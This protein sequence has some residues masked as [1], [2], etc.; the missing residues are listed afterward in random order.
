MAALLAFRANPNI[1]NQLLE[2]APK[3]LAFYGRRCFLL[4]RTCSSARGGWGLADG[5]IARRSIRI[6]R[7]VRVKGV[8]VHTQLL[9][10]F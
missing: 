7:T 5:R 1:P 4:G 10:G 2:A 8:A 3:S 9:S 6:A